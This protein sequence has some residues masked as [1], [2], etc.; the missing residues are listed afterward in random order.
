VIKII[1]LYKIFF[2]YDNGAVKEDRIEHL[3]ANNQEL[4][5]KEILDALYLR[6]SQY[7]VTLSILKI[8]KVNFKDDEKYIFF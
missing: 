8:Q 5:K 4:T 2:E 1:T 7:D 6:Y 3:A